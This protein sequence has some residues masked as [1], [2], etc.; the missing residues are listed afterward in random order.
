MRKYNVKCSSVVSPSEAQQKLTLITPPVTR[1]GIHDIHNPVP[2]NT[3]TGTPQ[4]PMQGLTIIPAGHLS[5]VITVRS[6]SIF[7]K[8][9]LSQSR[10]HL[11]DKSAY[12]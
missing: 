7:P 3:I 6:L 10:N 12:P 1:G 8:N 5:S 9:A 11:C 2:N 4:K